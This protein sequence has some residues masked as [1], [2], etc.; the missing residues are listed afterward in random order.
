MGTWQRPDDSCSDTLGTVRTAM[1][2]E[3]FWESA[4]GAVFQVTVPSAQTGVSYLRTN[5]NGAPTGTPGVFG[6]SAHY[7]PRGLPLLPAF[8][9]PLRYLPAMLFHTERARRC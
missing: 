7:I 9:E 8:G 4:L 3:P 6:G 1:G 2:I 5:R